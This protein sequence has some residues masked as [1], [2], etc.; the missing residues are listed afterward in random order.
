MCGKSS[1]PLVFWVKFVFD[2]SLVVRIPPSS[3]KCSM[4]TW[5]RGWHFRRQCEEES[6]GWTNSE[7]NARSRRASDPGS[8]DVAD[9][10]PDCVGGL[11]ESP[12][13]LVAWCN[14]RCKVRHALTCFTNDVYFTIVWRVWRHCDV[15]RENAMDWRK[16]NQ[17]TVTR[18]GATRQLSPVG[19]K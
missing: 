2:K 15:F 7:R 4:V 17:S 14:C 5:P 11:L 12:L 3:D 6:E 13:L 1:N 9:R 18:F 10:V 8:E 19:R 16:R